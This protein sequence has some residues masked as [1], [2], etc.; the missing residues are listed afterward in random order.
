MDY[1]F[2][3]G[4]KH[5][6]VDVSH[7]LPGS[8]SDSNGQFFTGGEIQIEEDGKAYSGYGT[9]IGGWNNGRSL[10]IPRNSI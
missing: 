7:Y 3:Q 1:S 5:V 2:P 8:P 6:L 10:A 4:E 9:Y